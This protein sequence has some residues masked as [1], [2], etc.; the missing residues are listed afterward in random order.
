MTRIMI[1]EDCGNSPKNLFV[2][3]LTIALT[4][5][6]LKSVLDRVTDDI[7]WNVV[8][9]GVIQGKDR[10]A[11]A[12]QEEKNDTAVELSIHHIATHGK[13][14]AVDGRM[15]FKSGK[16]HAFCNIYEFSNAKGIAIKE[17]ISYRIEIE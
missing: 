9:D 7:R 12:L 10:V 15:K 13:A 5:G 4:K 6:D 2:Q 8:G 11:E 14:S 16:T 3:E 17:I 1:G